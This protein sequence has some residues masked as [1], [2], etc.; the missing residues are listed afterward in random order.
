MPRPCILETGTNP[1][2]HCVQMTFE[3]VLTAGAGVASRAKGGPGQDAPGGQDALSADAN[4]LARLIAELEALRAAGAFE[5]VTSLRNQ[6]P[7]PSLKY[8]SDRIN[9]A[10]H[11]RNR[12]RLGSRGGGT[13]AASPRNRQETG[14]RRQESGDRG[15]GSGGQESEIRNTH[16]A[17]RFTHHTPHVNQTTHHRH[18]P[19]PRHRRRLGR[20][21]TWIASGPD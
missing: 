9:S 4:V 3:Q 5:H 6:F 15:Q 7:A 17:S 12:Q 20:P 2:N 18:Q 19:H 21:R 14:V 16:H 13:L 8:V 1:R 11:P 10:R